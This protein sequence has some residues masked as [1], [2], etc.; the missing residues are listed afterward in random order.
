MRS[1][2]SQLARSSISLWVCWHFH[3]EQKCS[4]C[5]QGQLQSGQFGGGGVMQWVPQP[6]HN[7]PPAQ[8]ELARPSRAVAVR[9]ISRFIR[10]CLLVGIVLLLTTS[11]GPPRLHIPHNLP[12]LG[13]I[14][15][16]SPDTDNI[17]RFV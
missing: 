10:G 13:A 4:P 3:W 6:R 16:L 1:Q 17:R 12:P 8:A 7:N 5:S 14:K 15:T 2:Q 9:I 11:I